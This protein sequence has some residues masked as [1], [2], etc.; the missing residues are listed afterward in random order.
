MIPRREFITFLGGAATWP[1]AASAQQRAMPVI[2]YLATRNAANDAAYVEAFR[3]GLAES[4]FIPGQNVAIEFRWANGQ[5]NQLP[6]FATELVR[7]HVNVLV[8]AGGE[9]AP[10]AKAATSTIP[11]VFS[12]GRDPVKSGLVQSLNRPGGNLTGMTTLNRELSA[13]RLGLLR[14]LVPG[15][16]TL[17]LMVDPSEGDAEGQI[18]DV[19]EAARQ[20]GRKLLVLRVRSTEAEIEA[21]FAMMAERAVGGVLIN[22][23]AAFL[24][25]GGL[26]VA[27]ATRLG[28]PSIY[29]AREWAAAGGLMSYSTSFIDSYHNVG[30]Y[31][32]RILKG[33]TP[34]NLPV[35]QPTKFELLINLQTARALKLTIPPGILAIATEVIE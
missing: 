22:G 10:V 11:L 20:I 21:A 2:G 7:L 4:G 23:Q 30:I 9:A 17:A 3:K 24:A 25:K 35:M 29:E 1:L 32:S 34:A 27:A 8:T 5:Y 26:V 18:T 14:D 15:D 28:V 19:Q 33:A 31:T 12:T 13:K 16:A 6:T